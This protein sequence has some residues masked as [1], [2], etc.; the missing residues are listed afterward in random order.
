[1]KEQEGGQII[2]TE[3]KSD[4]ILSHLIFPVILWSSYYII[5]LKWKNWE[6]EQLSD[7]SYVAQLVRGR[8]KVQV[9]IQRL[10]PFQSMLD[11]IF[12]FH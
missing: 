1:M 2:R 10:L 12:N 6:P 8:M 9:L 11:M 4:L 3:G 5:F 7:M